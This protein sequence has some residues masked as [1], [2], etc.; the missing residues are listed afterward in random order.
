MSERID[1]GQVTDRQSA[2][3]QSAAQRAVRARDLFNREDLAYKELLAMAM[4]EEANGFDP[5]TGTFFMEHE[6]PELVPDEVE[7]EDLVDAPDAPGTGNPAD[8]DEDLADALTPIN[9]ETEYVGSEDNARV[10]G[11]DFAEIADEIRADAAGWEDELEEQ[12][13]ELQRVLPISGDGDES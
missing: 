2:M 13:S 11:R 3:L 4:P 12:K 5:Q 7:D 10:E 8:E 1:L 9:P 6:G